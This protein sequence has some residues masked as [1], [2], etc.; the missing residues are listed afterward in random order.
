MAGGIIIYDGI[1]ALCSRS[2]RFI[3]ARDHEK[4][5]KFMTLQSPDAQELMKSH[6]L[7]G[8]S[9]VVVDNGNIYEHSDAILEICKH[10]K[11]G[12]KYLYYFKFIPK[13]VRNVVYKIIAKYRYQWFGKLQVCDIPSEEIRAR[14]L[15]D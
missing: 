2:V 12:V 5:F 13:T 10:L 8:N 7:K 4:Y 1:C 3:V 14:L 15:N 11:G 6:D 9:I